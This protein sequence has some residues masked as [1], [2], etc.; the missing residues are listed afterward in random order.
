[1]CRIEEMRLFKQVIFGIIFLLIAGLIIYGI[2]SVVFSSDPYPSYCYDGVQNREEEGIDCGGLCV[3]CNEEM[4]N[5]RIL[6]KKVFPTNTGTGLVVEIQNPDTQHAIK[7]FVYEITIRDIS[8]NIVDVM[9][10][11]SFLYA[12]EIKHLVYPSLSFS[13]GTI[14]SLEIETL[15]VKKVIKDEF[16]KPN[17]ITRSV[18]VQK[19]PIRVS[20]SLVNNEAISFNGAGVYALLYN[21]AGMLVGA[22][23]TNID[24]IGSLETVPFSIVFSPDLSIQEGT[25][26]VSTLFENNVARGDSGEDVYLLQSVLRELDFTQRD[27]TGFFDSITEDALKNFQLENNVSQT[28]MLDDETRF[29]LNQTLANQENTDTADHV[30]KKVDPTKTKVFVDIKR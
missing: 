11:Q 17:V 10:G 18:Q 19:D 29:I 24:D 21:R 1:M 20:G 28:G 26:N 8:G 25:S 15:D 9:E 27:P 12:G 3:P 5:V 7:S 13:F 6:D 22:S 14:T 30:S 23:K 4:S 16:Q 2:V